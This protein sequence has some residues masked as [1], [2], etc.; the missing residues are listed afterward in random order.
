MVVNVGLTLTE[1]L[2][3]VDVNVPGAIAIVS[4]PLVAQLSKLLE[5]EIMLSGP[6][7]NELI[8]GTAP[9]AG[10]CIDGFTEPQPANKAQP[11]RMRKCAL[12]F[13]PK[14]FL[15][16]ELGFLSQEELVDEIG[17]PSNRLLAIVSRVSVRDISPVMAA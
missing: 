10:D 17:L 5:P 3:D 9:F 8:V 4:A 2:V 16:G 6:A 13:R 14:D 1:P 7:V 15:S 12:R 11:S